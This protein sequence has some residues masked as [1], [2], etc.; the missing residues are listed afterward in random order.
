MFGRSETEAGFSDAE[1]IERVNTI[2]QLKLASKEDFQKNLV[3]YT[4]AHV[5]LSRQQRQIFFAKYTVNIK[6]KWCNT[7][8]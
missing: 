6:G 1:F 8:I 3:S 5:D 4:V 7:F 2:H